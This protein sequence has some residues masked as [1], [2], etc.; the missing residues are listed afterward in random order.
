MSR[1]WIDGLGSA[2]CEACDPSVG[3]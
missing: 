2:D 1:G 3:V